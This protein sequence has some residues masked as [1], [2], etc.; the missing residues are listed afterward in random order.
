MSDTSLR[1]HGITFSNLTQLPGGRNNRVFRAEGPDGA[2][3]IKHYFHN[4]SDARDRLDAEYSMLSF[5]HEHG[6]K[7]VPK[8]L[9]KDENAHTGVYGFLQGTP[10]NRD[11]VSENDVIALADLLYTM[12]DMRTVDTAQNL[13]F[14]SDACFTLREYAHKVASRIASLSHLSP[15]NLINRDVLNF[16]DNDLQPFFSIIHELCSADPILYDSALD[17]QFY[18]LSPSDHGFHNA[19]R[20]TDGTLYFVDFE[21][22]GW[23]DPA[24]MLCDP[25]LQPDIPVPEQYHTLFI[26]KM[27]P[28]INVIPMHT[29][30]I[31]FIYTILS[32]KWCCILLN[33]FMPVSD[34][35][36]KFSGN[37]PDDSRKLQQLELSRK[38]FDKTKY[39]FKHKYFLNLLSK[40]KQ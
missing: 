12:W 5:L 28:L 7:N 14:A 10:V 39:Q 36:R 16:V 37:I 2:V 13:A 35:R 30:K 19:I 21:Y 18:A 20:A 1:I 6:I 3:L 8:P 34:A 27:Q 38:L 33:E 31:S 11:S 24:K 15:D 22:S 23:D 9:L 29:D 17:T 32:V 4:P 25:L 40:A 26:K